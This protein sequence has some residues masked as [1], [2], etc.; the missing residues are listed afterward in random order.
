MSPVK[1]DLI[2]VTIAKKRYETLC[3]LWLKYFDAN[4]LANLL[5]WRHAQ[6]STN[7]SQP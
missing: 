5:Q 6:Q 4:A 7:V 2:D 1:Y 3:A